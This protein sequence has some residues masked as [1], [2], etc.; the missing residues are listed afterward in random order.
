MSISPTTMARI[1]AGNARPRTP[2]QRRF[3]RWLRTKDGATTFKA[4]SAYADKLSQRHEHFSADAIF[5]TIRTRRAL[6]GL[7]PHPS[8]NN[9]YTAYAARLW[10]GLNP[11]QEGFFKHRRT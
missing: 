9:N 1:F 6:R 5:H 11:S 8:I 10:E 3:F 7:P 2:I 4:F